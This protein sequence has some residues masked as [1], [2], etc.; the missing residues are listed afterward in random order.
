VVGSGVAACGAHVVVVCVVM[1]WA[2]V[3]V[4]HLLLLQVFYLVAG[5]VGELGE[6]VLP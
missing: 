1:A 5:A 6:D 3:A 4:H 2:G